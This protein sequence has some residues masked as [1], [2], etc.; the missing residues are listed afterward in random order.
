[1][2]LFYVCWRIYG[3]LG[4]I[5]RN[6]VQKDSYHF[7]LVRFGAQNELYNVG[8]PGCSEINVFIKL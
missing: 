5:R 4:I 1:M 6:Y 3:H 2:F 8:Q 7:V